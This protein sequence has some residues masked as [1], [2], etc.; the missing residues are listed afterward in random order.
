MSSPGGLDGKVIV[1]TGGTQG[2]GAATARL[3]AGRGAAGIT[4]VG[5]NPER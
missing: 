3:A 1:I 4:I 2:L 5:R